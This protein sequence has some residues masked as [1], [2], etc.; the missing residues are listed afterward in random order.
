MLA[1]APPSTL[2]GTLV[3]GAVSKSDKY[4]AKLKALDRK[5]LAIETESGGVFRRA[6]QAKCPAITIR[7]IS[8]HADQNKS[9]LEDSTG[10]KVRSIAASNAA[11]FLRLQ[12]DNPHFH[13]VINKHKDR[14]LFENLTH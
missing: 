1:L 12:L 5:V 10:Q 4:N 8:D 3:C 14:C 7:G 9:K 13:K 6:Q 11:T 2:G